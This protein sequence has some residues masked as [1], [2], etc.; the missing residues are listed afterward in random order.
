[1][2]SLTLTLILISSTSFGQ[3]KSI[4]K[5]TFIFGSIYTYSLPYIGKVENTIDI[6]FYHKNHIATVTRTS[7][8]KDKVT[9][10]YT[11]KRNEQGRVVEIN[12]NNVQQTIFKYKKDSL[13]AEMRVL[14]KGKIDETKLLEYDSKNRLVYL[15]SKTKSKQEEVLKHYQGKYLLSFERIKNGKTKS[16]SVYRR[17]FEDQLIA[18]YHYYGA[19]LKNKYVYS[20]SEKGEVIDKNER[21]QCNYT[22]EAA[23]GSFIKYSR[24][25]KKNE[26]TLFAYYYDR[27][28]NLVRNETFKNDTVLTQKEF[29]DGNKL[30]SEIYK[31]GKLK[32]VTT[33][34]FNTDQQLTRSTYQFVKRNK[35]KTAS[36]FNYTFN[37][38]GLV[39]EIVNTENPKYKRKLTY[40]FH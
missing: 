6:E 27:D 26:I 3:L 39:T 7:F 12:N 19:K 8:K 35:L 10:V 2:K 17:D 5:N 24:I 30:I 1:M 31:N 4:P 37:E 32:R 22:E 28:T 21:Q 18:S 25:I 33:H 15:S 38:Q 14:K 16:R 40:T 36:D 9:H 34:Y 29:I 20:C 13:I 23:D 11:E